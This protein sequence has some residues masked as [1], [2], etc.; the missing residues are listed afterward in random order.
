MFARVGRHVRQQYAG[1]LALFVALGGVSY[2][3]V[4]LPAN[5]VG[6]RQIKNGQVKK[7]DLG[8]NAVTAA[9]VQDGSLLSADFAPGQLT[10]GAPGATGAQG[11]QG[12][13]GDPGT[14]G[15]D[16]TSHTPLP[17]GQTESGVYSVAGGD[18]TAGSIVSVMQ[19]TQPLA[20][21]LD[22]AHVERTT[23]TS[24]NC[25]GPGQAMPGY[26]CAYERRLIN[27]TFGFIQ[28]PAFSTTVGASKYGAQ[29]FYIPTASGAVAYGT[30]AV[31]AP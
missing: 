4:T 20:A 2:A 14:N 17:S 16:L 21:D 10:A 9:K 7:A 30:W 29:I 19:F 18:S 6:S 24:A 26:L 11:L 8:S 27:A 13:K 15:T 12:P 28:N 23:T 31:T 3:A 22:S 25:P 5:S 1:F